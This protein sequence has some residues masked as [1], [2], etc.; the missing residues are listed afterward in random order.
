MPVKTGRAQEAVPKPDAAQPLGGRALTSIR[1]AARKELPTGDTWE[2]RNPAVSPFWGRSE[3]QQRDREGSE[4]NERLE[5][6]GLDLAGVEQWIRERAR[7]N[8]RE[9][10]GVCASSSAAVAPSPQRLPYHRAGDQRD[11]DEQNGQ[12]GSVHGI[13]APAVAR[14][15]AQGKN[16]Q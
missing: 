6:F 11:R 7:K 15:I 3:G 14:L 13:V 8:G 10:V 9:G 2:A 12:G 4:V 1:R 16:R 5:L